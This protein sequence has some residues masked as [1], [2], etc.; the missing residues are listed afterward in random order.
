M[1]NEKLNKNEVRPGEDLLAN[2]LEA[3]AGGKETPNDGLCFSGCESGC[4][5]GNEETPPPVE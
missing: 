4:D 3:I 5:K 2:E 1:A